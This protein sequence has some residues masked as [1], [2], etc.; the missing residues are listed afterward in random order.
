MLSVG[1]GA[2]VTRR[3]GVAKVELLLVQRAKDP[4]KGAWAVPGGRLHAGETLKQC[5]ER[6]VFEET[7]LRVVAHDRGCYAFQARAGDTHYVVVD[8]LAELA[9]GAAEDTPV[10]G[11]DAL[12][13][14]FVGREKFEQLPVHEETRR[15]VRELGLLEKLA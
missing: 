10:A 14:V 12:A 8:V 6:E 5:A 11:D 2:V 1:V 9:P 15:L 7:H 3:V 13:A 4:A